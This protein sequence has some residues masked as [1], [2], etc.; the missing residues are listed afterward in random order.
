[1]HL[2]KNI[3]V[4]GSLTYTLLLWEEKIRQ[5]IQKCISLKEMIYITGLFDT[6]LCYNQK[7][8]SDKISK[9]AYNF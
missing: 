8:R 4:L 9:N 1:M 7:Q 6:T 5:N 3:Y 2:I